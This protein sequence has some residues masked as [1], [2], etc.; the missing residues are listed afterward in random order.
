MGRTD[1]KSLRQL[2]PDVL[3]Q[4]RIDIAEEL[5]ARRLYKDF[6]SALA[7][8]REDRYHGPSCMLDPSPV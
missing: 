7:P 8:C 5:E 4:R 3:R 2:P 6:L 1:R